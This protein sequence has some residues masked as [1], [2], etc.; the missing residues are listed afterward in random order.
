MSDIAVTRRITVWKPGTSRVDFESNATTWGQ[1]RDE[2]ENKGIS[3]AGVKVVEGNTQSWIDIN[4]SNF[5]LPSNIN[6]RGVITNNLIIMLVSSAPIKSGLD[7]SY[8]DAR[9]IIKERIEEYGSEAKEHFG[10]YT[11]SSTKQLNDLISDWIMDHDEYDADDDEVTFKCEKALEKAVEK[12]EVKIIEKAVKDVCEEKSP[13]KEKVIREF[14][15]ILKKKIDEAVEEY[16]GKKVS[17]AEL[18]E[19]YNYSVRHSR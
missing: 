18:I 8:K 6:V 17:D 15:E 7:L 19:I 12:K 9:A 10:N 2:I 4:D 5:V 1:L 14:A 3:F 11:H 16:L 13:C